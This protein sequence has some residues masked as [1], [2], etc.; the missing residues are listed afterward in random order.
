MYEVIREGKWQ[1]A[2]NAIICGENLVR[3]I[4]RVAKDVLRDSKGNK[5][6]DKEVGSGMKISKQ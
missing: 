3:H 6:L 5:K 4:K 1:V 2:E